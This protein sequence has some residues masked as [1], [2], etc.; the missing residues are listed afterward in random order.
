[1]RKE[2]LELLDWGYLQGLAW[3]LLNEAALV[4]SVLEG[5]IS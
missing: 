1:M 3:P 5:A 2:Q 4:H